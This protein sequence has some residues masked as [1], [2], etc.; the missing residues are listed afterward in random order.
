V[1]KKQKRVD[2]VE[3][4]RRAK[5]ELKSSEPPIDS[6]Y[7]TIQCP[8]TSQRKIGEYSD[9]ENDF[10]YR[11]IESLTHPFYVIDADNYTILLAN[12]ASGIDMSRG[13]VKCYEL[14]HSRNAPCNGL[15]HPCPLHE[16]AE[17]KAPLV[18]EHTHYNEDGNERYLEIHAYPVL[19]AAGKVI[20]I[21]EYDFDV[22]EQRW[23]EFQLE[24]ETKR[25]RL[26]LDLLA[27]DMAN[28][29]QI[30]SCSIELMLPRIQESN[31]SMLLQAI[32][33][34]RNALVR[35]SAMISKARASEQLRWAPLVARNLPSAILEASE[36]LSELYDDFTV[37]LEFDVNEA[38]VLADKYLEQLLFNLM[39]NAIVHNPKNDKGIWIK[40]TEIMDAYRII[41]EDNG[42]GIAPEAIEMLFDP[43]HRVGGLGLHLSKEIIAKY[44]G[45]L[46]AH[47]RLN[48]G[49]QLG[50]EFVII[51]PRLGCVLNEQG[52]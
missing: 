25:S 50:A 23:I 14:T 41:I 16:I 43:T 15:S 27:H 33:N 24:N 4:K 22:T 13:K 30:L 49:H 37:H 18:V 9:A 52:Q 19:D 2:E 5:D 38:T 17:K 35:S 31:D 26:Y 8:A 1:H 47:N 45:R 21:I 10:L 6:P 51:L 34:I 48:G 11:V 20:Q 46:Q 7:D 40:L 42:P 39:E 36:I 29:L 28:Q 12:S 3:N 44:S 32:Q